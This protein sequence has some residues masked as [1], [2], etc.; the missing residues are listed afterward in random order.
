MWV[1]N[2]VLATNKF[3]VVSGKSAAVEPTRLAKPARWILFLFLVI[4]FLFTTCAPIIATLVTSLTK[5]YGLP[6]GMEN[7]TFQNF[8][9]MLQIQNVA[10]AFKNSLFLSVTA[11]III[12]LV[13]LIIAYITI[14]GGVRGIKGVRFMQL[15]VV[16]PYDPALSSLCP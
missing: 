3:V 11:S 5:T 2:K 1:Y 13:T 15:V 6:F 12:T 16:L 10:R 4:F 9:Q 7:M 8:A 14:R